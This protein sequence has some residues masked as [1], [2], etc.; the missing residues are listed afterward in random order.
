MDRICLSVAIVPI[1]REFSWSVSLQAR[2]PVYYRV[3]Y[4]TVFIVILALTNKHAAGN[5][6]VSFLVRLYG[7]TALGWHAC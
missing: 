2:Q 1:A 4:Y 3:S 7:N 6:S 5:R